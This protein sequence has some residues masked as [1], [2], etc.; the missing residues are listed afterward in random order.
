MSL[1]TP[2]Q[3][4]DLVIADLDNAHHAKTGEFLHA[5]KH[6]DLL[7]GHFK[8]AV[9]AAVEQAIAT[10]KAAQSQKIEDIE[11]HLRKHI[12]S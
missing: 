7:I 12:P 2:D 11:P 8:N 6:R 10:V 3:Y 5:G 9:T 1:Y 4:A